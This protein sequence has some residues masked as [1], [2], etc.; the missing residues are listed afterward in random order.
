MISTT[1][2]LAVLALCS[3]GCSQTARA[4]WWDSGTASQPAAPFLTEAAA[5][6]RAIS[7]APVT[8]TDAGPQPL[9]TAKPGPP[10]V[11]ESREP[12]RGNYEVRALVRL[13][14]DATPGASALFRLGRRSESNPGIQ[15]YLYATRGNSYVQCEVRS[16]DGKPL[17]DVAALAKN[18]AWTPAPAAAYLY[19]VKAYS[20]FLPGWPEAFRA[21]IEHDMSR[22]SERDDK[23]VA[24]RVDFAAG[25]LRVW[26]DDRLIATKD[27]PELDP[28]GAAR[29]ELSQGAQLASYRAAPLSPHDDR[30]LTLPI[31]G[32]AN[33]RGF[34]GGVALDPGSLPAAGKTVRVQGVPFVFAGVD[35]EGL[36]HL[37]IGESLFRQANGTDYIATNGYRWVGSAWRDPARIQLRFANGQYDSLY[38]VAASDGEKD[39]LPLV[40]AQFFRPNAGY[41]ERFEARVPLATATSS[42]ATRLGVR[43]EN[44]KPVNLWLI[45]LA[46]DPGRLSSFADLDVLEM[47][48]TKKVHLFR[49]YPDPYT[50]DYY[51]GGPPSGV[52]VY[53]AT[54][55]RVPVGFSFDPDKFGH[56][57][58]APAVPSYTATLTNNLTAAERGT[59]TVT[60]RSYD[61]TETTVSQK[62]VSLA[63]GG[64]A[65]IAFVFPVKLNGTHD[66]TATLAIAGISWTEK[67]S[68]ARLAPDTR[69]A[70]WEEGKGALFG[71]W[72]FHGGHYTPKGALIREVMTDAGARSSIH[73]SV[74]AADEPAMKHWAPS[75]SGAWSVAP[76]TWASEQPVDPAKRAAFKAQVIKNYSDE[77]SQVPEDLRPDFVAFFPEPSI[78]QRLTNGF[79]PSYWGE[80]D[81]ALSPYEKDRVRMFRATAEIAAEA[82]KEKWPNLKILIPWGD[83]L[84]A[85]PLL[86]DGIGKNVIDGS[87]IDIPAFER[88]PEMQ[89]HQL[90]PN[91]VYVLRKE[92]E[93]AG[94]ANPTLTYVEGIV[95]PTHEAALSWREQMDIYNRW[96]LLAMSYG[97]TRFYAGWNAYDLGSYY[98]AEH[99]GNV[100]IQRRIPYCDPKPAYAAFATMTDKLNQA[101]YDGWLPTGSLSTYCLRFKGPRGMVYALWT[102]RGKRP[103]RLTLKA[104]RSATVTDAMNNAKALTGES[105]TVLTS[106]SVIYVTDAEVAAAVVGA[107]DNSD[108]APPDTALPV[109]D[110]GD[111][112]WQFNAECDE[113]YEQS[114]FGIQR[115]QGNFTASF[116]SDAVHGKVLQSRLEKQDKVHEMMPWYRN[117]APAKPIELRGAPSHLAL[118]VR[119]SSDW[120]RVVYTLRDADGEKWVS[121]GQKDDW[122]NDDTHSWTS[123]NFDGWRYLRFE[124]P[125]HLGYD[126]FREHGTT[127]WGSYGGGSTA[128]RGIVDLPLTLENIK[129]EQRSHVLYVNDV[130]PAASNQV[131]LGKL[132][133]EYAA[134][135]DRTPEAVRL[136]RWRM[137]LPPVPT[138]LP[139][140]IGEMERNGVGAA[141][142]VTA[143][144]PPEHEYDGTRANITFAEVPG[145]KRYFV[146]VSAH[147]DG[148]GAINMTPAGATNN[149]LITGLRAGSPLYYWV[150]YEDGEGKPSKPS[151]AYE[152]TLVDNFAQK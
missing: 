34:L 94:I 147:A 24:V 149:V 8:L 144:T 95:A 121:V 135:E 50:Y 42:G 73:G 141:T 65:K 36:D 125:G 116:A 41:P 117:L 19:Q 60:T 39:S 6:W 137:P 21:S 38:L 35:Q 100:G 66:V 58:T 123:F 140:P 62:P 84:F 105:V 13:R 52:H 26:V 150:A 92:Y 126:N 16:G 103:V 109:A 27:A 113:A 128:G 76:Q 75:P 136:S 64:G 1:K 87:A 152:A 11:L 59:L 40:T 81:Y 55:G 104:G 80:P 138:N 119:G 78:S 14:T 32:Y 29:L 72:S 54:L 67:R 97:I 12:L 83:P 68:L 28:T 133:V 131:E 43:L 71:Y 120:G 115:Y 69:S 30:F 106:P 146:W 132:Y 85:V 37:D 82:V 31:T 96:S 127:W 17:H 108:S 44:G 86:R 139:N 47:E 56:V 143:L 33:A 3:M 110:L 7:G 89:F 118:W 129:V 57:W 134:P 111:G 102:L 107:A 91:R 25:H 93:R 148:A 74:P 10:L 70:K 90:T 51:Q 23:F 49:S 151:P 5:D 15:L 124:L 9:L 20:Q 88:M 2:I 145:A 18:L 45:K 22:L 112:S 77:W 46:L 114:N 101:N 98:G 48:L 53:A 63:A 79:Y 99:Y 61:G 130:Q 4:A 122:N 142:R